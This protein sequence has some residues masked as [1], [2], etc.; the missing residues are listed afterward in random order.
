MSLIHELRSRYSTPSRLLGMPGPD[1]D[2]LQRMLEVAVHVPDHGQLRPWR[3]LRIHG[4]A[5]LALGRA[6]VS[7]LIQR[8]PDASA[9][10]REKESGRFKHAPCI[11]AV[12]ATLTPEHKVPESEQIQSGS[13]A[14]FAL[15]QAADAL[16]FGA[17]WL[18][19]WAAY[20]QDILALLGVGANERVLGF[21]H[22]GTAQHPHEDRQRP[23]PASL[24]TDW[25]PP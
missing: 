1:D 14:C 9:A 13:C 16:G 8:E 18:T 6:L 7:R 10:R 21:I 20:D 22:I 4:D 12:I 24:L 3:F 5:R 15:L 11:I 2:Q 23:D 19:G 25:Q 17:Q